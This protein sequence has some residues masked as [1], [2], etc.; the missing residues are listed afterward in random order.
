MM[1]VRAKLI[2]LVLYWS[3]RLAIWKLCWRFM[4][5]VAT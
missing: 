4:V 5:T 2:L 1:T 3:F